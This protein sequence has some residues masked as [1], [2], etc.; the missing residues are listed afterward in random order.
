[1]VEAN[2][3]MQPLMGGSPRFMVTGPK[4]NHTFPI[5]MAVNAVDTDHPIVD[6]GCGSGDV[7]SSTGQ[8]LMKKSSRENYEDAQVSLPNGK[9]NMFG[10]NTGHMSQS[11]VVDN[12]MY[13]NIKSPLLRG[14]D[15]IRGSLHIPPHKR[16]YFDVSVDSRDIRSSYIEQHNIRGKEI[17]DKLAFLGLR[18]DQIS[19]PDHTLMHGRHHD[20]KVTFGTDIGVSSNG[21]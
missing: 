10:N 2:R 14:T 13:A 12:L 3:N 15:P 11:V 17:D 20:I 21:L 16:G 4:L 8:V 19:S 1:M 7:R 9:V 5:D 6:Y 18:E